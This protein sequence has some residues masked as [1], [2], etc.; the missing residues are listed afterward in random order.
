MDLSQID[1]NRPEIMSGIEVNRFCDCCIKR[2][3]LKK[4]E[5]EKLLIN[6]NKILTPS[7]NWVE[8]NPNFDNFAYK[9]IPEEQNTITQ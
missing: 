8:T 9:S 3:K 2:S 6:E 1:A 5:R 4:L 7:L